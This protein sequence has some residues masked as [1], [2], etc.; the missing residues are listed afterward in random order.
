ML[1]SPDAVDHENG[2]IQLPDPL[3]FTDRRVS[4]ID[5]LAINITVPDG[6]TSTSK[7]PVL[8]YIHGGGFATGSTNWPLY[9]F[10]NL[11]RR[12]VAR[13]APGIGIGI[14]Y[15]TGIAGFLYSSDL[16]AAGYKANR[17]LRD[18]KLALEWIKKHIA[19]FGG[20]PDNITI[21]GQS[22]GS[23]SVAYLLQQEEPL[24]KRAIM[25][26]GTD[27]L[28]RASPESD[29][30]YNTACKLLGLEG[31]AATKVK[32]LVEYPALDLL[33]KLG[34]SV[35]TGAVFDNDYI[36]VQNTRD[37]LLQGTS[38]RPFGKWME[39]V[40]IGDCTFDVSNASALKARLLTSWVGLDLYYDDPV[41]YCKPFP[42]SCQQ[43]T[44]C[45]CGA[46][47]GTGI[48]CE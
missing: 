33:G 48:W 5:G 36:K 27:L 34:R 40:L 42:W 30:S 28:M 12:A 47:A 26:S 45:D 37:G 8:A 16:K 43:G 41:Q 24:A 6:G 4:D 35:N 14:N 15:R 46:D 7:L 19:G 29:D 25:M 3:P 17:G 21:A 1:N 11:V 20:D 38:K 32:A 9:D 10:S 44:T 23:G 18:Q 13:G 22:A 31:D 2:L 39:S